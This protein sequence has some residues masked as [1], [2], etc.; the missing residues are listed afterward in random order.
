MTKYLAII[1]LIISGSILGYLYVKLDKI[2][3]GTIIAPPLEQE[4]TVYVVH[5]YQDGIHRF[6]GQIKLPH[7]CYTVNAKAESPSNDSSKVNIILTTEDHLL[8][9]KIC[10]S[11]RTR[12]PF[13]VI[14]DA[15][16]NV[17]TTLILDGVVQP[18]K[19]TETNWQAPQGTQF[20]TLIEEI[21]KQ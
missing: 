9:E 10:S 12:Y 5:S 6:A 17:T 15:P 8:D 13:Q 1:V 2:G 7:S 14:A 21:P 19:I 16:Q 18:I 3:S 4:N 20:N 11:I